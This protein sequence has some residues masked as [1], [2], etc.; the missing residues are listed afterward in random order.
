MI[1]M[2]MKA[3]LEAINKRVWI[4]G[5]CGTELIVNPKNLP[6]K[7]KKSFKKALI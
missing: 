2:N 3:K 6:R 1:V 7:R 4:C 5:K